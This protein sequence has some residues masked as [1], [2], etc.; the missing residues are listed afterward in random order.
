VQITAAGAAPSA[1]HAA[2]AAAFD[3]VAQ[4]HGLMSFHAPDSDIGRLNR[5]ASVRAV[6]VHAWTFAVLEAALDFHRRSTG[7]FDIAVAPILQNLCLLPQHAGLF[8]RPQ[9]GRSL[10]ADRFPTAAEV[11]LLP[12]HRVRF[13]HPDVRIDLGGI[14][15]GFAVDRAIDVL[16]HHEMPGGVVNA[17]GD[18]AAFG[19][20]SE[21][22]CLR[23]PRDPRRLICRIEIDNEALASS[24]HFFDPLTSGRAAGTA[25]IDPCTRQPVETFIGAT[26]RAPSCM[27]ADALTKAVMIAG[28]SAAALLQHYG[29]GAVVVSAEGDVQMTPDLQ[30]AVCLAA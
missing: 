17:G 13:H 6:G 5:E 14:A 19:S 21:P 30:S 22:V 9:A 24:A 10:G 4:V 15:K 11:E 29:A 16:R 20:G 12:E 26:V 3:A 7:A 27:V 23:D 1:T 8:P 2:V 18:L 28:P 25:I